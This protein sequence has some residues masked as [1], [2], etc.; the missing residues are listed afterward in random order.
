DLFNKAREGS[1]ITAAKDAIEYSS[2]S[3]LSG[4]PTFLL[5]YSCITAH[6]AVTLLEGKYPPLQG[7]YHFGLRS[8]LMQP[9]I[10]VYY[11]K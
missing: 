2:A 4:K 11:L 8:S 7:Q 10:Q 6:F 9:A 5:C 3:S 1:D